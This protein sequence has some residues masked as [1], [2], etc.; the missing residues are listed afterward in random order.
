MKYKRIYQTLEQC[1]AKITYDGSGWKNAGGIYAY[2]NQRRP[3]WIVAEA[4]KAKLRLWIS[5]DSG[6]LSV[7]TADMSF[8]IDSQEY[9]QSHTHRKFRTQGELAGYL[10]SLL[11]ES[12]SAAA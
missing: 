5:H 8:S 6:C 11:G 4:E 12:S 9:H 2:M 7:T 1:G 10:E 3:L